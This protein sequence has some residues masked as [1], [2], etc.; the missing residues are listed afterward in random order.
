MSATTNKNN[1]EQLLFGAVHDY[2]AECDISSESASEN[3]LDFIGNVVKYLFKDKRWVHPDITLKQKF[4]LYC[5]NACCVRMTPTSDNLCRMQPHLINLIIEVGLVYSQYCAQNKLT[6]EKGHITHS[7][8]QKLYTN[9]Q[10]CSDEV[11]R[12]NCYDY[13]HS[14]ND[15]A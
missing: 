4:C 12:Y 14:D 6:N 9:L 1:C 11:Q 5:I 15:P 10:E 2:I 8:Q 13:M 7:G 3:F